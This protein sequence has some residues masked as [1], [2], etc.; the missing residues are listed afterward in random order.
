[1]YY[2][3]KLTPEDLIPSDDDDDSEYKQSS[4]E[5]S[6]NDDE[7]NEG[8]E[9]DQDTDQEVEKILVPSTKKRN[10]T[11]PTLVTKNKSNRKPRSHKKKPEEGETKKSN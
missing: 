1:M 4:G 6:E 9:A 3:S 7:D 11:R 2:F 8:E 5:S 10:K